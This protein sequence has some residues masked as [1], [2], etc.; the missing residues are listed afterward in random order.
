MKAAS[1]RLAVLGICV[2]IAAA[3]LPGAV[4]AA[5]PGF[6][7]SE[8]GG[9]GSRLGGMA[10]TIDVQTGSVDANITLGEGS[11]ALNW[12]LAN[13][14]PQGQAALIV[15]S[16]FGL[17]LTTASGSVDTFDVCGVVGPQAVNVSGQRGSGVHVGFRNTENDAT[18][19]A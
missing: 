4:F 14:E 18:P 1:A 7:Q 19:C 10:G 12:S 8:P 6:M 11:L 2:L 9:P 17:S 13:S 16:Q 5:G 3:L 15:P